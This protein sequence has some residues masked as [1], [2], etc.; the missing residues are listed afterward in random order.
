MNES[1]PRSNVPYL[2]SSE[3]KAWKKKKKVRL[4][5]PGNLN[6]TWMLAVFVALP[7]SLLASHLYSPAWLL[8]MLVTSNILPLWRWPLGVIQDT[9]EGGIPDTRHHRVTLS[10]SV[11]FWSWIAGMDEGTKI[12]NKKEN[13]IQFISRGVVFNHSQAQIG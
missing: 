4:R 9:I 3:N 1:D 11:A 5:V 6:W 8:L 10:P 12:W 2:G 7:H 13:Y